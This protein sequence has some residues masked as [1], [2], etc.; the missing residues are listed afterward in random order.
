MGGQ[1]RSWKGAQW[2]GAVKEMV[3]ADTLICHCTGNPASRSVEMTW[4]GLSSGENSVLLLAASPA[5]Q[6]SPSH[7][8]HPMGLVQ[9]EDAGPRPVSHPVMLSLALPDG[10]QTAG[11]H[12]LLKGGSRLS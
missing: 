1:L 5:P 8:V 3:K 10:E 12:V 7:K 6:C 4:F 2:E 11:S 9:C